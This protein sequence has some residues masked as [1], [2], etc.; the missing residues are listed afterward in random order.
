MKASGRRS[1]V[2]CHPVPRNG[3]HGVVLVR[4]QDVNSAVNMRPQKS[5]ATDQRG[6]GCVLVLLVLGDQVNCIRKALGR[7]LDHL[8]IAAE[9][10][11]MKA[12]VREIWRNP[13]NPSRRVSTQASGVRNLGMAKS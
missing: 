6:R 8:R 7:T 9:L 5:A 11:R 1:V 2:A 10:M 13:M 3:C 4:G 12:T